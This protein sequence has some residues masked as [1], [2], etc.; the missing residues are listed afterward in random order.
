ME[1]VDLRPKTALVG[2]L[3]G[4][5]TLVAGNKVFAKLKDENGITLELIFPKQKLLSVINSKSIYFRYQIFKKRDGLASVMLR[6]D[7]DTETGVKEMFDGY[8]EKKKVKQ[9]LNSIKK[10][11]LQ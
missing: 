4:K 6:L 5:I 8:A 7:K 2:E 10:E 3:Y 11:K 9:I 1:I